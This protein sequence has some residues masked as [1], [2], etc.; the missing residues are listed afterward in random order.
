[1]GRSSHS[2][3]GFLHIGA[4]GI[5]GIAGC[6]GNTNSDT[7]QSQDYDDTDEDTSSKGSESEGESKATESQEIPDNGAVVFVYD[8]GP[9]EDYTQALPAHQAFD[10][11]ATTGIV[12]EWIGREDFQGNDWMDIG[13]LEE[14]VDAG[15]EICSH[16]VDHTAVGTF[17]VVE[18]A[19][20]AD[21]RVY[22]DEIRHGYWEPRRLEITDGSQAVT[23]TVRGWD[24][25]HKGR[26]IDLDEPLGTSFAA[27]ET[28]TR[29][30]EEEMWKAIVESKQKLENLGFQID[31]FLAPYDSFDEYPLEFA[32]KHYEGVANANHGSRINDPDEFDPFQT[33]R[34]YFIEFTTPEA[35]KED[36]DIIADKGALG[37]IGA[38]TFK[39]EV[40]EE[41]IYETLEWIEDR[42]I[43]VVTLREACRYQ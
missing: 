32:K 11:P 26:Y 24:E 34:D 35:V 39:D 25:D 27:G 1:M 29:Y 42:E 31:T 15:W 9:I 4:I 10:A 8:D 16:T 20:A 33:R 7:D 13:H 18:D 30:P 40:T 23:R 3:R 6:V 43:D 21:T 41:R 22:P 36:L 38:H 14:L 37:V 17:E 2:R 5:G 19:T 28:V 12:T